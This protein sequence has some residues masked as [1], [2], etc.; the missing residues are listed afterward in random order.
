EATVRSVLHQASI[1]P[2]GSVNYPQDYYR[3]AGIQGDMKR[4]SRGVRGTR[5]IPEAIGFLSAGDQTYFGL[6]IDSVQV[7]LN[8]CVTVSIR[9]LR[10]IRRIGGIEPVCLFPGIG[11]AVVVCIGGRHARFHLGPAA[12]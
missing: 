7:L 2:S 9:I 12:D 6:R 3:H 5:D 8:I 4:L 10:S 1:T 11:H